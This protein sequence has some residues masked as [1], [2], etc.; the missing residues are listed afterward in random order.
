MDKFSRSPGQESPELTDSVIGQIFDS[1]DGRVCT[2]WMHYL[3]IYDRLLAPWRGTDVK[4][5]ELGV[6]KGGSLQLWRK[7]LGPDATIHGIDIDPACAKLSSDDL[8][9]HIGSQADHDFLRA[10]V[11]RM[12]GVD[13][14]LDDG[15]HVAR[16]QR[17]S[18]DVLFPLLPAGGLYI[19]EDTHTAYWAR[20]GG[21]Y[22]RPGTAIQMS[23]AL[24]DG[25]HAWYHR[26][27]LGRRA[28]W[29]KEQIQ[30]I[31][32]FDSM[33]VIEKSLR[34]HPIVEQRGTEIGA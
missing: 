5:L 18:F 17:A 3:P 34:T 32:F 20:H 24:V 7:Y 21:G 15:S 2:K 23:K 16:H 33:V 4:M 8:P 10:V 1:H 27:P 19:I 6:H 11:D 22:R 14:V 26:V 13:V 12:G 28:R 29:A 9:V 25:M 31:S 30:A